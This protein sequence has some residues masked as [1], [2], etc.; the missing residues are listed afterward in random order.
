MCHHISISDF[1]F[2]V[3]LLWQPLIRPMSCLSGD[4]A[5]LGAKPSN[6][7][8]TFNQCVMV[9]PV[10][11]FY[12]GCIHIYMHLTVPLAYESLCQYEY[13][14]TQWTSIAPVSRIS[15]DLIT[16]NMPV[17]GVSDCSQRCSDQETSL[18]MLW[19]VLASSIN[20]RG[21]LSCRLCRV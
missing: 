4:I 1:M 21:F 12:R 13:M 5:A 15:F 19:S 3:G 14:C 7:L 10:E 11:R 18:W 6:I 8:E 20:M 17:V 2:Y 16:V 9:Y